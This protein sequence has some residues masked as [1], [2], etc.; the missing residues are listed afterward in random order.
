MKQ[1]VWTRKQ[2]AAR[3][4]KGHGRGEG[5]GYRPWL[6]PKDFSSRGT[7]R[8]APG[9]SNGRQHSLFSDHEWRAFLACQHLRDVIDIREQFPLWGLDQTEAIAKSFGFRHPAPVGAE[10]QVMTTDLLLTMRD[11][12]LAAIA[13][14]PAADLEKA[15]VLEK[16]EI[17]RRYWELRNIKWSIVTERELPPDLSANLQALAGCHQIPPDTMLADTI[18]TVEAELMAMLLA[19]PALP[20]ETHCRAVD[21]RMALQRGS[22]LMVAK[23]A[24][25]H[26]RWE[27]RLDVSIDGKKPLILMMDRSPNGENEFNTSCSAVAQGSLAPLRSALVERGNKS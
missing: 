10:P 1:A 18:A 8:R 17:E 14:K 26:R 22:S 23:H 16:L 11:R 12:S 7:S 2:A 9:K 19:E 24:L 15:R 6:E 20:L 25:A 21:E 27:A 13:V 5:A 4:A 3:Y